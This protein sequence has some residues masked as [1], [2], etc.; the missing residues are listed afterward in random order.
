M[1]QFIPHG[2]SAFE[3]KGRILIL[4]SRGPFNAEHVRSTAPSFV[5]AAEQLKPLGP[6]A[7]INVIF[8]SLLGTPEALEA[9]RGSALFTRDE[10]GRCCAAYVADEQVEGRSLMM[11]AL[12]RSCD[13]VIPIEFFLDLDSAETWCR[14]Q[15]ALAEHQRQSL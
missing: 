15:I 7:T 14:Q 12:R 6:W 5:R 13:G 3:I 2:S 4:R 11:P 10:L 9:M 8:E 1:T